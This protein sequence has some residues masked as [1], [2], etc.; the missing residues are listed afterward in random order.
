MD[1]IITVQ[2]DRSTW[3]RIQ[4]NWTSVLLDPWTLQQLVQ[5]YH[6]CWVSSTDQEGSDNRDNS[7]TKQVKLKHRQIASIHL[8]P[9]LAEQSVLE[10][11][12]N[13]T[14]LSIRTRLFVAQVAHLRQSQEICCRILHADR[15]NNWWCKGQRLDSIFTL[16]GPQIFL[17][18]W[19]PWASP[20]HIKGE[21]APPTATA[22]GGILPEQQ[23][24]I[25]GLWQTNWSNEPHLN[26]CVSRITS[27]TN[28]LPALPYPTARHPGKEIAKYNL[29]Q[30][31]WRLRHTCY[32]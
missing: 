22:V 10:D 15:N 17:W 29:P 20:K 18:Q 21:W 16:H 27:I 2:S 23:N 28:P 5:V 24:C 31:H 32:W 11:F 13:P 3:F 30:Q 7:K 4:M 8:P 25:S 14:W 19:I 9:Q 6:Q 12:H 26:W 1:R